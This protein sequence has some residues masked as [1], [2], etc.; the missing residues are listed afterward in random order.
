MRWRV[1]NA[2]S[3]WPAYGEQLGGG[4]AAPLADAAP[5]LVAQLQ[6][7]HAG[8]HV[9]HDAGEAPAHGHVAAVHERAQA[10][11]PPAQGPAVH[12]AYAE[13]LHAD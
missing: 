2:C 7:E 3:E 4:P 12:R 10:E 11:G 6:V 8:A 9:Q 1:C 13:R 5:H